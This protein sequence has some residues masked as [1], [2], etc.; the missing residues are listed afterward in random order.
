MSSSA[1]MPHPRRVTAPIRGVAVV[2]GNLRPSLAKMDGTGKL[3][4][5][6][7]LI[8]GETTGI[9]AATAKASRQRAPG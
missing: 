9:G 4:N 6:I 5:K 2:R 8:T 1:P 3:S 7:A